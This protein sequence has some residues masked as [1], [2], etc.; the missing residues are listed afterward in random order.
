VD[1]E[2]KQRNELVGWQLK[3]KAEWGGGQQLHDLDQVASFARRREKARGMG[4]GMG[5]GRETG[6][7]VT[8]LTQPP[9]KR[10]KCP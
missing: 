2:Q 9:M 5:A 3:G 8:L 7:G 1:G 4:G 6:E 10:L